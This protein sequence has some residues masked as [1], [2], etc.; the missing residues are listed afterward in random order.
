MQLVAK[1][2]WQIALIVDQELVEFSQCGIEFA[3]SRQ[4]TLLIQKTGDTGDGH[5]SL[6]GGGIVAIVTGQSV[7]DQAQQDAANEGCGEIGNGKGF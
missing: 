6:L 7:I 5:Q 4:R 1:L 3:R 2:L